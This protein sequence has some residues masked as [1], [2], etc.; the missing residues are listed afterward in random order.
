MAQLAKVDVL[1]AAACPN[2]RQRV[3]DLDLDEVDGGA[4]HQCLFCGHFM[5]IPQSI[6]DKLVAQREAALAAQQENSSFFDR[7]IAFFASLFSK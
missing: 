4:Q 1:A 7:V 6:I 3:T 5:N 2:C